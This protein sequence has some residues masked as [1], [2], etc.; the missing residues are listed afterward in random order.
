M[1]TVIPLKKIHS[2]DYLSKEELEELVLKGETDDSEV[3]ESL[4]S[5]LKIG[6]GER[7]KA[8]VFEQDSFYRILRGRGIV[9]AYSYLNQ[10]NIPVVLLPPNHPDIPAYVRQ[11]KW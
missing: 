1:T 7:P 10:E 11:N 6:F 5:L 3:V 4:R 9:T 8:V 2:Q